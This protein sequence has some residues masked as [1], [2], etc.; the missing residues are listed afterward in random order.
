MTAAELCA[1]LHHFWLPF[2]Q[3]GG[4]HWLSENQPTFVDVA[5]AE[6][7]GGDRTEG[8]IGCMVT[9]TGACVAYAW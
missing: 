2:L 3:V 9:F 8:S 7:E 5:A 6:R 4:A 1:H